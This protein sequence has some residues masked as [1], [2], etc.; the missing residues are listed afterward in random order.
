VCI[1]NYTMAYVKLISGA[2]EAT[3]A[4]RSLSDKL[5]NSAQCDSLRV[6]R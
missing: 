4:A 2:R 3:D 6:I 5:S 1:V